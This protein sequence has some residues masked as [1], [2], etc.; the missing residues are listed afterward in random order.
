MS[1]KNDPLQI[2]YR[3]ETRD[4]IAKAMTKNLLNIGANYERFMHVAR[5]HR[6]SF[7]P[8]YRT[9]R[10]EV[11]KD[12]YR[13]K[14]ETIREASIEYEEVENLNFMSDFVL[15]EQQLPFVKDLA[16]HADIFSFLQGMSTRVKDRCHMK[17]FGENPSAMLESYIAVKRL[18]KQELLSYARSRKTKFISFEELKKLLAAFVLFDTRNRDVLEALKLAVAKGSE[19]HIILYQNAL[20]EF[21]F[22]R[23]PSLMN[24]LI[25]L[26]PDVIRQKVFSKIA[27]LNMTMKQRLVLYGY[28]KMRLERE[29]V[30]PTLK[31]MNQ[32]AQKMNILNDTKIRFHDYIKT[33]VENIENR[34][35]MYTILFLDKELGKVRKLYVPQDVMKPHVSY[36]EVIRMTYTEMAVIK[37]F[38]TKDYMDLWHGIFSSDCVGLD[39]GQKHLLTPNF[40]NVRIFMND[41]WIGNIYMLD[42]TDR[43]ILLI[44]RIQIP[45]DIPAGFMGF[46]QGLAEVFQEMFSEVPYKEIL[47]PLAIS[48]HNKIQT[49]FNKYKDTLPKKR[50]YFD[51]YDF[52][53]FASVANQ[54]GWEYC[55]LCTKAGASIEQIA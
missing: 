49:V 10:K 32:I 1:S 40:F 34:E 54:R 19:T 21:L 33:L 27:K 8:A 51:V 39:L 37:F 13:L 23:I 11:R 46:F 9:A 45:R 14:E 22:S 12:F 7:P 44:D 36:K 35:E 16:E 52:H 24:E 26:E 50:V 15:L 41:R 31:K 3:L 53:D 2:P 48:N 38:P 4:D 28:Y 18:L 17:S 42:F 47:M 5:L 55:I 43:E 25:V 30:V 6:L 29:R 20:A